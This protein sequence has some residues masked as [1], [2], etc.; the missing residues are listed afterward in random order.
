M[1]VYAFQSQCTLYEPFLNLHYKLWDLRQK[2]AVDTFTQKYQ[3]TA[4]SFSEAGD[5][6]FAGSIDNE[7]KVKKKNIIGKIST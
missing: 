7:I 2:E 4:T 5:L 6:V 1:H 3:I